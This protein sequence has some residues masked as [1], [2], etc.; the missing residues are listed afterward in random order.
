MN[1]HSVFLT[2]VIALL[3]LAT[4]STVVADEALDAATAEMEGALGIVPPFIALLPDGA[5][6]GAWEFWT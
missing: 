3:L 6:P 4:T 2:S 1:I 5:Q